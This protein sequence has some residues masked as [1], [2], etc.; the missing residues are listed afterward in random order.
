MD[1]Y[2]GIA[3]AMIFVNHVPGNVWENF[4]SRNFGYSD[5]AELFV[6]LAGF[7]SAFAYGKLFLAG[8]PL[9]ASIKAWRRAGVLYLVHLMIM[10]M[11]MAIFAWSALAF[12]EGRLLDHMNLTPLLTRPLDVLIGIPT[13]AHQ[14]G[15]VNILPM[16]S[17]MLLV[18]PVLLL[19]ARIDLRLMLGVSG[20]VWFLAATFRIDMP[21]YPNSGGWFFNPIAWQFLFAI[22]LACGLNKMRRGVSVPYHPILFAL[23]AAYV[24]SALIVDAFTLWG[25]EAYLPL[26][27]ALRNFDKTY[28]TAPLLLH[29]LSLIYV[30]ANA[31][32]TSPLARVRKD[33]PFTMLG[34]HSLPV[35][36]TGTVLSLIGQV[37]I[38]DTKPDLLRD[39]L[40]LGA[41]LILQFLLARY[42]DWWRV[43]SKVKVPSAASAPEARRPQVGF[44]P[45][46]RRAPS[47]MAGAGESTRPHGAMSAAERRRVDVAAL[48]AQTGL[49]QPS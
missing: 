11:A 15:Y 46:M 40:L 33:N 30:F 37:I 41:G 16:Y 27:F 8:E 4:T 36:A 48:P 24:I 38:F 39:T 20:L 3:L 18:V 7:A 9:I 31:S 25:W 6:F 26:P 13:L 47:L 28:V 43:A 19:L 29:V 12:G 17:V 14:F 42:L 5:A 32:K 49:K 23:A 21:N 22:G 10:A 44:V 2:R 35:F 34:R 45:E 1:F